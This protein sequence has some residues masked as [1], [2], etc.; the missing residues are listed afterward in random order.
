MKNLLNWVFEYEENAPKSNLLIRIMAGWIFFWEGVIKFVFQNQG[1]GRFTKIGFPVP[2]F[3]STFVALLEIIGGLLLI[4]G[5]YTRLITIPFIIEMLVAMLSTKIAI[6][7]GSSPLAPPPG[8]P[9][10]GFYAVLHEFRSE[11][12]QLICCLYLMLNGPGPLSLDA[13]FFRKK[14]P[15]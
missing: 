6:F 11:L 13:V 5:F 15:L 2:E 10:T 8:P 14:T 3:T 1:V 12:S 4:F 9:L 7:M